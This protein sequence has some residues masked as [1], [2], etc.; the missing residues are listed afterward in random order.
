MPVVQD[1]RGHARIATAYLCTGIP[2][3]L[4]RQVDSATHPAAHLDP[5]A[6]DRATGREAPTEAGLFET[7]AA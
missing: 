1:M 7:L 2:I 5:R 6:T 3:N 4:L